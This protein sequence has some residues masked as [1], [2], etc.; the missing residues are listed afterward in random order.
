M[1]IKTPVMLWFD[2]L[3]FSSTGPAVAYF[4]VCAHERKIRRPVMFDSPVGEQEQ[5]VKPYHC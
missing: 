5:T 1:L 3:Q 2:D 4:S